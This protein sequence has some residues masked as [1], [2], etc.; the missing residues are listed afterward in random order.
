MIVASSHGGNRNDIDSRWG[1]L[2][3]AIPKRDFV[4]VVIVCNGS[5]STLS[6]TLI[7]CLQCLVFPQPLSHSVSTPSALVV[8]PSS[9]PEVEQNYVSSL[10]VL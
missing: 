4:S 7:L 6:Q 10:L 1:P 2:Q 3:I 9:V 8:E 5:S